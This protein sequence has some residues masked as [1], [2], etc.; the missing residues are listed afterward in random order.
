MKGEQRDLIKYRLEQA[1]ESLIA[2]KIL[3]DQGLLRP[4]ASRSYYAMFYAALALLVTSKSI[5]SKHSGVLSAFDT[6]FILNGTLDRNLSKWIHEAHLLRIRS[7]YK[8]MFQ[9]S[10]EKT[11]TVLQNATV[12]VSEVVKY[13]S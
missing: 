7:D 11:R 13:L 10:E 2:A 4:S 1:Q 9:I 12:F 5:T 8:D 6:N 3:L